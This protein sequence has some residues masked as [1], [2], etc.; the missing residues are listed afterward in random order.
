MPRLF[1]ALE[2]PEIIVNQLA[3]T[4]GGVGS[5]GTQVADAPPPRKRWLMSHYKPPS[6]A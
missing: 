3:L 6:P 5:P 2:L 4:R 1:T